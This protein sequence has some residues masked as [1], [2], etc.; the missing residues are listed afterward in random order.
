M[1]Q[2]DKKTSSIWKIE[3]YHVITHDLSDSLKATYTQSQMYK[4]SEQTI[5]YQNQGHFFSS[6]RQRNLVYITLKNI[7]TTFITVSPDIIL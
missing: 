7:Y 5:L 3:K 4:V 2:T 6:R 1:C